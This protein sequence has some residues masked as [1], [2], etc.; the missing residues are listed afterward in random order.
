MRRRRIESDHN[1]TAVGVA[2]CFRKEALRNAVMEN[3]LQGGNL[4]HAGKKDFT[5][6]LRQTILEERHMRKAGVFD[7][8]M[9]TGAII[10][11]AKLVNCVFV[12]EAI[13]DL[14]RKQHMQEYAFG[15]FAKYQYAWVFEDA[16]LFERPFP[17]TGKR[18]LWDFD[19]KMCLKRME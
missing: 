10:G 1:F 2:A 6:A 19:E 9:I 3:R 12:D 15:Y 13:Q 4:N 18:G 14:M 5:N 8:E 16:E 7:T 17:T 11:K